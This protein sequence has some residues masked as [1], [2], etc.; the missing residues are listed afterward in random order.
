MND[1]V[2]AAVEAFNVVSQVSKAQ[3]AFDFIAQYKTETGHRPS[4]SSIV[5]L[6]QEAQAKVE[7]LQAQVDAQ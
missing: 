3:A 1:N 7:E 6:W 4:L 2:V 5:M